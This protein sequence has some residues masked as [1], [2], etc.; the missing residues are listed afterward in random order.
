MKPQNQLLVYT[1][2]SNLGILAGPYGFTGWARG[3]TGW[4][5]P[6][7]SSALTRTVRV[8]PP[9]NPAQPGPSRSLVVVLSSS[10]DRSLS[11]IIN[12]VLRSGLVVLFIH[13]SMSDML[14][15]A[16]DEF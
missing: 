3:F 7:L 16:Y 14:L 1:I 5:G 4:V 12:I 6:R 15:K 10:F 8:D 2:Y 11:R 13:L 9:Q